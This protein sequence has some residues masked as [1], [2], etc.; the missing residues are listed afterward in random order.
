MQELSPRALLDRL[1][2]FPTVSS[3]SNL[4]LVDWLEGYLAGHGIECHRHW[5]DDGQ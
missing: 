4:A 1:V 5:N 3:D 2:A